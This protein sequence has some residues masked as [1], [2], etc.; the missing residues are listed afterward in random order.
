MLTNPIVIE[1]LRYG[2]FLA[3]VSAMKPASVAESAI[4]GALINRAIVV[5][6]I[7]NWLTLGVLRV[8]PR[9]LKTAMMVFNYVRTKKK[10]S[11]K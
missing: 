11:L 3:R 5:P 2:S 10:I 8:F 9:P 7:K 6:G 4:K 1:Q